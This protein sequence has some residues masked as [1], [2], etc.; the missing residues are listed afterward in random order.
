MHDYRQIGQMLIARGKITE[1]Q[2]QMALK[3]RR[4]SRRRIGEVLTDMGFVSELDVAECLA[5]QFGL[6]LVDPA[7]LSPGPDALDAIPKDVA[8]EYRVLPVRYNWKEISCVVADP[9]DFPASDMI[10]RISGRRVLLQLAPATQ[11]IVAIMRAYGIV[12]ADTPIPEVR[13]VRIAKI[14]P[15]TDRR[16]IL[17]LLAGDASTENAL[18]EGR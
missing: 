15:Q 7:T 17:A 2:L 16:A 9:L 11:L 3:G 4:G 12:H 13:R 8:L 1:Q 10:A 6:Q 14:R 5:E 18:A